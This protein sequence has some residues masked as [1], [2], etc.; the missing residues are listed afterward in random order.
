MKKR[1]IKPHTGRLALLSLALGAAIA[2]F[3]EPASMAIPGLLVTYLGNF[4]EYHHI[5][6]LAAVA[7]LCAFAVY[8]VSFLAVSDFADTVYRKML[9]ILDDRKLLPI[10]FKPKIRIAFKNVYSDMTS[11]INSLADMLQDTKADKDKFSK[12]VDRSEERRVG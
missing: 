6:S 9:K 11:V 12:T 2:W 10:S 8:I 5:I 3:F 7:A 4:K 1:S